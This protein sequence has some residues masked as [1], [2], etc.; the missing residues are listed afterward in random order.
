MPRGGLRPP[1]RR[2]W[3]QGEGGTGAQI[4]DAEDEGHA[5][6]APRPFGSAQ[7][8][9]APE[10]HRDDHRG[11]SRAAR[12]L[13]AIPPGTRASAHDR[14]G[15]GSLRHALAVFCSF[16]S[17]RGTLVAGTAGRAEVLS[18]R[19]D[20]DMRG[21]LVRVAAAWMRQAAHHRHQAPS[22]V[23]STQTNKG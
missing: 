5:L 10:G 7:E 3:T 1:S 20:T 4:R 18:R 17:G 11:R 6:A 15:R 12:V 23:L 13:T 2:P 8:G 14:P 9:E 16:A 21:S 19:R 22:P